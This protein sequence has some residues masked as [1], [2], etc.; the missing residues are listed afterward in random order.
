[1]KINNENNNTIAH[2]DYL[3]KINYKF[4]KNPNLKYKFNITN[5]ND[6]VYGANDIFEVYI[7]YKDNKEYLVSPNINNYYLDIFAL[8][9]NKK[10][11]SLEGHTTNITNIRYF[12]NNKDFNEYLIWSCYNKKVIIWDITDNFSIKYQ[13]NTEFKNIFYIYSCLLVFPHNYQENFIIISSFGNELSSK[14]YSFENGKFIKY[15]YPNNKFIFYLLSWYN[16]RNNK[17]YIIQLADSE[18]IITNLL[19]DDLYSKLIHEINYYYICGFIYNKNN[20]DYLCCSTTNG[21]IKIWDLYNKN[22]FK[23]INTN[24]AKT[25][26]WLMHIIEWNNKYIIVADFRNYSF[27]I[28]DI[29]IGKVISNYKVPHKII[30]I[31]KLKHPIYGESLLVGDDDNRIE[32]FSI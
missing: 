14:I 4:N 27:K 5:T 28:I 17:Y 24:K 20:N 22:I 10:I 32:L 23:I 9:D 26:N 7:S 18:I 13:I 19:E 8:L 29:E 21:F 31:K 1:M 6:S 15:I 11:K 3:N 30:S 2:R 25:N 16:K 12:I